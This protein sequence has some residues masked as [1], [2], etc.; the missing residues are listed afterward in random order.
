M[1]V[2]LI[3]REISVSESDLARILG[4]AEVTVDLKDSDGARDVRR[5]LRALNPSAPVTVRGKSVIVPA[6]FLPTVRAY[7]RGE[8]PP[9]LYRGHMPSDFYSWKGSIYERQ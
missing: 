6:S 5:V 8:I 3:K 9:E 7:L 2:K 4:N 1:S